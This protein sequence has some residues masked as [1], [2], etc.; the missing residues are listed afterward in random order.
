MKTILFATVAL[1]VMAAPAAYAQPAH[2]GPAYASMHDD[3]G[4]RWHPDD[5]AQKRRPHWTT[6]QRLSQAYRGNT[7]DYRRHHLDAPPY[8]YRWVQADDQYLL[9]GI[10]SGL[11]ASIIAGH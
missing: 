4:G 8:G 9:I 3:H 5:R 7:V 10:A 11:I 6:G 2:F 1:S